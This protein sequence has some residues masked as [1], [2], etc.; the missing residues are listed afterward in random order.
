MRKYRGLVI[1]SDK[2]CEGIAD[3]ISFGRMDDGSTCYHMLDKD[4]NELS[5]IW[6]SRRGRLPDGIRGQ[7]GVNSIFFE[8]G[9]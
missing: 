7:F 9:E 8:E 2:H 4:G 1:N 5:D 3:F 6:Y